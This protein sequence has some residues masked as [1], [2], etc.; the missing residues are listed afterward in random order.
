MVGKNAP[1]ANVLSV[2]N[3]DSSHPMHALLANLPGNSLSEKI[4]TAI[5]SCRPPV[6]SCGKS[7]TFRNIKNGYSQYC[8]AQCRENNPTTADKRKSTCIK[9][10]GTENAYQN[11]DIQKKIKDKILAKYG[12]DCILKH[13][14]SR[15]SLK[16]HR[17]LHLDQIIEKT[18]NTNIDKYGV[19]CTLWNSE[20]RKKVL[21]TYSQRGVTHNSQLPEVKLKKRNIKYRR[22]SLFEDE[23]ISV[24]K[25][26]GFTGKIVRNTRSVISPLEIDIWLP[27]LKLGIECNG[28]Y[29]HSDPIKPKDYHIN[30]TK[31]VESVGGQLIHIFD[32]EWK[33]KKEQI[34]HRLKSALGLGE[35]IG[36]RKCKVV[37]LRVGEANAFFSVYHT[38]GPCAAKTAFGLMLGD[39][40][41]A[42][43]T[44]SKPRYSK[45][46]DYELLRYASAANVS[47]GA[48]RLIKAFRKKFNGSII[49]YADRKWSK[50]LLYHNMGFQLVNES[51]PSY[52]YFKGLQVKHRS[53]LQKFK[54][55]GLDTY[56]ERL[57]EVQNAYLAGWRRYFDCGT[58][59]FELK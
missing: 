7:L 9:K 4:Y 2:L 28:A 16:K 52:W 48:S 26:M 34:T 33:T 42:A 41:V 23:V 24:I 47:G 10:Y 30:K 17:A 57:T 51:S 27:D 58:L 12:V 46:Y 21:Y 6:C 14:S 29:W 55:K 31:L 39:R 43:A 20:V 44:F 15:E 11:K 3:K 25:S 18:K 59:V 38:Q 54:L 35:K 8:S 40:L 45:K 36:A 13:S 37:E 49:S 19:V 32:L 50:G 5:H 22:V 53:A 56:D 1:F